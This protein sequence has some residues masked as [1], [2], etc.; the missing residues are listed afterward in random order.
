M[1]FKGKKSVRLLLPVS[2]SPWGSKRWW[3]YGMVQCMMVKITDHFFHSFFTSSSSSFSF[4]L[5]MCLCVACCLCAWNGKVSHGTLFPLIL[6]D[7]EKRTRRKCIIRT[8]TPACVS[9]RVY[10][11]VS[12]SLIL[13]FFCL[14]PGCTSSF[15]P[16]VKEPRTL[17][18]LFEGDSFT[19]NTHTHREAV[20]HAHVTAESTLTTAWYTHRD[21]CDVILLVSPSQHRNRVCCSWGILTLSCWQDAKQHHSSPLGIHEK[22]TFKSGEGCYSCNTSSRSLL[23]LLTTEWSEE[24]EPE[25]ILLPNLFSTT[26]KNLTW[27]KWKDWQHTG[28][29]KER[30]GYKN[31]QSAS[32]REEDEREDAGEEEGEDQKLL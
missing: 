9:V 10:V 5:C 30:K 25:L 2:P 20:R 27:R 24:K 17:V 26:H 29:R 11:C 19:R 21:P 32:R 6:P 3:W 28:T 8:Q 13:F 1:N 23:L 12:L 31:I 18:R 4:S 15:Q 14:H 22:T 16:S 7:T